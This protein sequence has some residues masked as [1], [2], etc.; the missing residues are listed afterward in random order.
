MT[1]SFTDGLNSNLNGSG[2]LPDPEADAQ[3]YNG[4]P[5]K[6]LVAF[7][8]DVVLVWG[9]AILFSVLTLG[10]GFLILGFLIAVIDLIYRTLTIGSNSAT[11]G[12]SLMGIELRTFNGGR[13]SMVHALIHTLLFYAML[14]FVVVQLIS[15]IMMGGTRYG[16]GLHDFI[17]GSAMINRPV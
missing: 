17:L 15:V 16:R 5:A 9:A 4:V 7:I 6:R 10:I 3:F 11:F 12:M 13:F 1:H 8:I 2:G 14:A